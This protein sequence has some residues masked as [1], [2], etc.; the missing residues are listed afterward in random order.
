MERKQINRALIFLL[1]QFLS[2]LLNSRNTF[3]IALL[4]LPVEP[5]HLEENIP[6]EDKKKLYQSGIDAALDYFRK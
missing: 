5:A 4:K 2:L 6:E 3:L 1:F